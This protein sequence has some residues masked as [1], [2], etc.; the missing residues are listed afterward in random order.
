MSRVASDSGMADAARGPQAV[1]ACNPMVQLFTNW[2]ASQI[3]RAL[4]SFQGGSATLME[5]TAFGLV[6]VEGVEPARTENKC[7]LEREARGE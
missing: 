1:V 5:L 3:A 4:Y 6:I 2:S 7:C